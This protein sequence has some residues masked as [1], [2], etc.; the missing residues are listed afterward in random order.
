MDRIGPYPQPS[1]PMPV[2]TGP[3][4]LRARHVVTSA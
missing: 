4:G 3:G 2:P 1:V